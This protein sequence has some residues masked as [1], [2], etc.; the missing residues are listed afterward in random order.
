MD[1]IPLLVKGTLVLQFFSVSGDANFSMKHTGLTIGGFTQPFV[2]RNLID[3]QANVEKGLCQRFLWLVPEPNL[4][5]YEQMCKADAD[6]TTGI[7]EYS[8]CIPPP[9]SQFQF[10]YVFI[11]LYSQSYVEPLGV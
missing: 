6:F 3:V 1:Y 2:A 5:T 8:P 7:G 4:V 11:F 10:C 9:P